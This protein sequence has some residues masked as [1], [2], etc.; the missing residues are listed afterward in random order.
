MR[1]AFLGAVC[2]LTVALANTA[3]ASTP[4]TE[5]QIYP[6]EEKG[7]VIF[8]ASGL[9][10]IL[11][12]P[13]EPL[14]FEKAWDF[15][16]YLEKTINA[17]AVLDDYGELV[18]VRGF[19]TILDEPCVPD[20]DTGLCIPP[21]SPVK[22]FIGGKTG[23]VQIGDD[24]ICVDPEKCE[25]SGTY[26]AAIST[27]LRA[28]AAP[29]MTAASN[30]EFLIDGHSLAG[31]YFFREVGT[32]TKQVRG[33]YKRFDQICEWW[34]IFTLCWDEHGWNN[35]K[36]ETLIYD[37]EGTL[38]RHP[39]PAW[40]HNCNKVTQVYWGIALGAVDTDTAAPWIWKGV[41]G[42]HW[43]EGSGGK[44]SDVSCAANACN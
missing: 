26:T 27:T 19:A 25:G 3:A 11:E 35:M 30:D 21:E 14:K 23:L 22:A 12:V 32:W 6:G 28:Q 42:W 18:G 8:D 15:Y 31:G 38:V 1:P 9:Q 37:K 29:L 17:E 5:V 16:A 39:D 33:G 24:F 20:D 10:L 44:D 43:A 2:V 40:C 34:F 7:D 41:E 36:T 13:E 4:G